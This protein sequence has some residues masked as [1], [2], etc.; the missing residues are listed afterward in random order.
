VENK[1]VTSTHLVVLQKCFKTFFSEITDCIEQKLYV[2]HH[3]I[4]MD[5]YRRYKNKLTVVSTGLNWMEYLEENLMQFSSRYWI[6]CNIRDQCDLLISVVLSRIWSSHGVLHRPSCRTFFSSPC[7]RQCE[8]LPSLGI[9]LPSSVNF[10][11]FNLLLWNPS[12][13]WTETW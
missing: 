13:K 7:Q 6:H 3:L 10:S 9:R 2:N 8:L 1:L 5:I 4:V 12:A 11:H